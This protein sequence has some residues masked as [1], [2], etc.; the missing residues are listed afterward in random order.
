MFSVIGN[1]AGDD[2]SGALLVMWFT[3]ISACCGVFLFVFITLFE[4]G[5]N[6]YTWGY[7]KQKDS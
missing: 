5:C 2:V 7:V 3:H 6:C 4:K 1:Q